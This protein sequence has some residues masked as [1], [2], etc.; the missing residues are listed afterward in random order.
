MHLKIINLKLKSLRAKIF[1]SISYLNLDYLSH[2]SVF[3]NNKLEQI[4]FSSYFCV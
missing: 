3:L 1:C 2:K 4:N